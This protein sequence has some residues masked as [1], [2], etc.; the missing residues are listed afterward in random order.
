MQFVHFR[1]ETTLDSDPCF[2]LQR[3]ELPKSG[4]V[5]VRKYLQ[6]SCDGDCWEVAKRELNL[7]K[8]LNS[9]AIVQPIELKRW[10]S[11]PCLLLTDPGGDLLKKALTSG[12]LSQREA[13][14]LGILLTPPL[15]TL[16]QSRLVHG[17]LCPE[18]VLYDREAGSLS[19]LGFDQAQYVDDIPKPNIDCNRSRLPY[20]APELSG[21]TTRN[22]DCRAD[23]YSVGA[24]LYE[25][26]TGQPPFLHNDPLKL[27]HSHMAVTPSP[28]S[29]LRPELSGKVDSLVLKLL[30]KEPA[31][32]YQS[33]RGL[34]NELRRV[35]EELHPGER[36][37]GTP[38]A[39]NETMSFDFPSKLYGREEE[40]ETLHSCF[41]RIQSGPGET[42]LISGVSGSGKTSLVSAFRESLTRSRA[43]FATGKFEQLRRDVPYGAIVPAL[44]ET[45]QKLQTE[46]EVTL[47]QW[48]E[49]ARELPGEDLS[50]LARAIPRLAQMLNLQ[51]SS[52]PIHDPLQATYLKAFQGLIQS[53]AERDR[54]LVL[55]LD[56]VQWADKSSINLLVQLTT[57][58]RLQG[59]LLLLAYRREEVVGD[60]PF[61]QVLSKLAE[62]GD[63]KTVLM[64]ELTPAQIT[65]LLSDTLLRPP[66][67]VCELARLV[68][69]KTEG[70][71]FYVR[72]FLSL[73]HSNGHLLFNP[74]EGWFE[75]VQQGLE[76]I[77]VMANV[78]E[79][80]S[81][82]LHKLPPCSL[83]LVTLASVFGGRF[84]SRTLARLAGIEHASALT[85]LRVAMAGGW[86]AEVSGEPGTEDEESHQ[87]VFLHDRIQ[88]A[89]YDLL[90]TESLPGLHLDLGRL[91]LNELTEEQREE[92]LFEILSHLNSGHLLQVSRNAECQET[93]KDTAERLKLLELNLRAG[94]RS[95][96]SAAFDA[97]VIHYRHAQELSDWQQDHRATY[98]AHYSLSRSLLL[99]GRPKA[100]LQSL[101]STLRFELSA[102][103]LCQLETLALKIFVTLGDA[104]SAI[105]RAVRGAAHL[106]I[107]LPVDPVEARRLT[108]KRMAVVMTWLSEGPTERLYE[109][110]EIGDERIRAIL[111]LLIETIPPTFMYAPHLMALCSAKQMALTLEHGSS[112]HTPRIILNFTVLL[113]AGSQRKLAYELGRIAVELDRLK[114]EPEREPIN[115]FIFGDLVAAWMIP[116]EESSEYIDQSF[117]GSLRHGYNEQAVW[118][119]LIYFLQKLFQGTSLRPLRKWMV[120]GAELSS[121]FEIGI[122][123]HVLSGTEALSRELLEGPDENWHG[124]DAEMSAVESLESTGNTTFGGILHTTRIIRY[125]FQGEYEKAHSVALES[126]DCASQNSGMTF[127]IVHTFFAQLSFAQ[128]PDALSVQG[129]ARLEEAIAWFESESLNCQENF[130]C[131]L[132][133]LRAELKR[134]RDK[135]LEACECYDRA[136]AEA[137]KARCRMVEAMANELAGRHWEALGKMDFAVGYLRQARTAYSRWGCLPKVRQLEQTYPG[138]FEMVGSRPNSQAGHAV[139]YEALLRVSRLVSGELEL[140]NLLTIVGEILV[141]TAGAQKGVIALV[142]D[143]EWK[144]AASCI[145]GETTQTTTGETALSSS[146][147]LPFGLANFVARNGERILLDDARSEHLF[148]NDSYIVENQPKSILCTPIVHK[149]QPIGLVYLE[150]NLLTG[151]FSGAGLEALELLISQM[152]ISIENARLFNKARKQT[153]EL[154]SLNER[155]EERVKERTRELLESNQRLVAESQARSRMENELRLAQKLQ[156]VGQLAAGIAH[157]INT[158]LQYLGDNLSF[159]QEAFSDVV[160]VVERIA[161][162]SVEQT[163]KAELFDGVDLDFYLEEVPDALANSVDGVDKVS[164]IVKAMRTSS[165]PDLGEKTAL[166]VNQILKDALLLSRSE[167]KFVAEVQQDLAELPSIDGYAGA[168]SQVFINLIVNAAHAIQE[169]FRGSDRTGILQVSTRF[170]E[171][172]VVAR[173]T[174]NG[175]GIEESHREKLFD[176]FFTTKEVGKGTGQGLSIARSA[177]QRHGGELN[178]TTETDSGSTFEVRLPTAGRAEKAA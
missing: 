46:D 43:Y 122:M 171:G 146:K 41:E 24:I 17:A 140:N 60:H 92:R 19:L 6:A 149:S 155:L 18:N 80:L 147:L 32:R 76:S 178:F 23:L 78:A 177:V 125:Y 59:F 84:G 25:A 36:Y 44:E 107:R 45:L 121:K 175:C 4:C 86:I 7:L 61:A 127:T 106:G 72:Q 66:N 52:A 3:G 135:P 137:G 173:V 53:L 98:L 151:A 112:R 16:S 95:L 134:L 8:S 111:D 159:L 34:K 157:E 105:E 114:P 113:A 35:L 33:A 141:Q 12:P 158:P 21:Q 96:A 88:K 142:D 167:Y 29:A 131:K 97:A 73:L 37:A 165:H 163:M 15:E 65:K 118:S 77:S 119:I 26:L 160:S 172:W 69:A 117:R 68:F 62:H 82:S 2:T 48:V 63:S 101:E 154:E 152:A 28:P 30:E 139:Q 130:R 115:P 40:L 75:V 169:R 11:Q 161:S 89:A 55:F 156:S 103:E 123:S 57:G 94:E 47:A 109:L 58:Q 144:V 51:P 153:R 102:V 74:E 133:L 166:D 124:G 5:L 39:E 9:P 22:T 138:A 100:A 10:D 128:C 81:Q 126:L 120:E 14:K 129:L 162:S 90:P 38:P 110:E 70:N 64:H 20:S 71:P 27:I 143:G 148:N 93:L 132:E 50:L 108:E 83:R 150:N 56:D 176:P 91:L 164:A 170:E 168:L 13:L 1:E 87:F 49:R 85:Y 54:P 104:P 136:I 99:D 145:A 79:L 67:S 31:K 42:L 174:D 116:F